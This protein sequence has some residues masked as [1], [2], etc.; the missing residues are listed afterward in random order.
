MKQRI[1]RKIMLEE[2]KKRIIVQMSKEMR[3]SV[4]KGEKM[5]MTSSSCVRKLSETYFSE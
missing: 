2:K 4:M 5:M 3:E 1:S